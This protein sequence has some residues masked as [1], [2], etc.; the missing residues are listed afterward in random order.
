MQHHAKID[1]CYFNALARYHRAGLV[2][3]VLIPRECDCRLNECITFNG[4]IKFRIVRIAATD[5]SSTHNVVFM[6][7]AS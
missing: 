5:L 6:K 4:Q 7:C 1:T 2:V 3:G